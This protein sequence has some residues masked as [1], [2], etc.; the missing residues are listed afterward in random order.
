M[1]DV[2]GEDW[3]TVMGLLDSGSQ[4]S[5]VNKRLSHSALTNP[6]LKSDPVTM[7]MADG[8]RSPSAITH[9]HDVVV[10]VAGSEERMALDSSSLSHDLIFGIPW[11]RKHNPHIDYEEET[12]TFRSEFCRQHCTH[13]GQTVRLYRRD[14]KPE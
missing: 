14:D 4:G 11:H 8:N 9:Y 6:K 10:R 3:T 2:G 5:C 1:R 12:L 13:Y 7:I